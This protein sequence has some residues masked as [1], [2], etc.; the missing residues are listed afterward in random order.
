MLA[1]TPETTGSVW[2]RLLVLV[3]PFF[4]DESGS[5]LEN[6]ESSIEEV[7]PPLTPSD[8]V[9]P[10][11]VCVLVWVLVLVVERPFN[12]CSMCVGTDVEASSF[13][14]CRFAALALPARSLPSQYD[15]TTTRSISCRGFTNFVG[16]LRDSC[17]QGLT[18]SHSLDNRFKDISRSIA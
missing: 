11:C 14:F 10:V 15:L 16:E 17:Q 1:A 8:G 12:T 2:F 5:S 4:A 6:G 18:A 3:R 7:V 13:C 9:S